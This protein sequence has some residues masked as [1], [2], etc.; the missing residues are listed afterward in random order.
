MKSPSIFSGKLWIIFI[1]KDTLTSI[2]HC[3]T[4]LQSSFTRAV[5]LIIVVLLGVLFVCLFVCLFWFLFVCFGIG[6]SRQ[7]FSVYP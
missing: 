2:G 5:L 7:G 4:L 6:F 3:S 1:V